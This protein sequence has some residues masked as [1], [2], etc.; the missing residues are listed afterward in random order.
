MNLELSI[1]TYPGLLFGIRTYE[2]D[3]CNDYVAYIPFVD[4]CLTIFNE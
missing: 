2:Q 3:N 4:I 1:G